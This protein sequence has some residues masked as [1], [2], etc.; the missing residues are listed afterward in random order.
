MW[1]TYITWVLVSQ[2]EIRLLL[3]FLALRKKGVNYVANNFKSEHILIGNNKKKFHDPLPRNKRKTHSQTVFFPLSIALPD[4][5]R[6][7]TL[8]SKLME[9]IVKCVTTE[10][11][12]PYVCWQPIWEREQS[13]SFR[14]DSNHSND[15]IN[16]RHIWR[17]YLTV[18]QNAS[19]EI[20]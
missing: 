2:L 16:T 14:H 15:E 20:W 4:G 12:N 19:K 1:I 5:T 8:K 6:R 17:V 10:P 18:P 13:L 3:K 9:V 11:S 7:E